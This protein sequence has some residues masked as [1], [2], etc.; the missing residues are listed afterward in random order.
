MSSEVISETG[1]STGSSAVT[2]YLDLEVLARDLPL[3]DSLEVDDFFDGSDSLVIL[4]LVLLSGL[5]QLKGLRHHD[6]FFSKLSL[7]LLDQI[8]V[9]FVHLFK[10]NRTGSGIVVTGGASMVIGGV[11]ISV[12]VYSSTCDMEETVGG[13]RRVVAGATKGVYVG[14]W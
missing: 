13:G 14:I 9:E 2:N 1:S 11:G 4:F 3:D 12:V 6:L 7:D 10:E 8:G 5:V